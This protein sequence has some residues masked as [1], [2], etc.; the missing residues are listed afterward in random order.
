[1]TPRLEPLKPYGFKPYPYAVFDIETNAPTNDK[2]WA[3]GYSNEGREYNAFSVE[4]PEGFSK[5]F[6]PEEIGG[7]I[8]LFLTKIFNGP[9]STIYSHNGG[10][11]DLQYVT[12][13][14]VEFAEPFNLTAEIIPISSSIMALDVRQGRKRWKFL[15]S[16]RIM[17]M[18]LDK[19]A[20]TFGLPNKKTPEGVD[21]DEW[22]ANLYRNPDRWDYLATDVEIL[23]G[24]LSKFVEEVRTIGGDVAI[25]GAATA[26]RTYRRSYMP[27]DI[28]INRHFRNCEKLEGENDG[29]CIGC[30][31]DFFRDGYYGGRVEPYFC[32]PFESDIPVFYGDVNSMYP[33]AMLQIM[34]T[35]PY[36]EDSTRFAPKW[37]RETGFVDAT[38]T[39][40]ESC[41]LPPLPYRHKGKLIFPCGTFRGTWE[42]SELSLLFRIGG[43]V[44]EV[45]KAMWAEGNFIFNKYVKEL[46][47]LR[48]K[49]ASD[50]SEGRAAIA[51]ILLNA[52]YGKFGTNYQR[53]KIWIHPTAEEIRD[54]NM[55]HMLSDFA[56]LFTES[57]VSYPDYL[58]PQLA[59]RITALARAQLWG[60][61][62]EALEHGKKL[63]YCDT[64]SIVSTHEY[65]WSEQLGGLKLEKTAHSG[66]FAA[67]KLYRF[68]DSESDEF[69]KQKGFGRGFTSRKDTRADWDDV[70]SGREYLVS[71][72]SKLKTWARDSNGPQVL[73]AEK[74]RKSKYDKRRV[75]ASG[76]TSP[77]IIKD[78]EL[79]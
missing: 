58:I 31:H 37:E 43:T 52:L 48:D 59:A 51:K 64:D 14:I 5:P 4:S 23:C 12:R 9:S 36:T 55:K 29:E 13:W 72:L 8:D 7:P 78:G 79:T 24:S 22:Y 38:V 25:S 61:M 33:F 35:E 56:P 49:K 27:L 53:E 62:Y 76:E 17:P 67:P 50:Y 20:K 39:V 60:L 44:R 30:A 66:H 74:A 54:K 26:M 6:A 19:I 15:D 11:F 21:K 69:R 40:P 65:K 71:R 46:Y 75:L 18:S 68:G 10:G 57:V 77:W 2:V 28:A 32:A 63:Y 73:V 42:A 47:R 34:P 70:V 3:V 41:Y 16:Y 1:V 45:H